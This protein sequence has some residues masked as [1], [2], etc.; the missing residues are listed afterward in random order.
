MWVNVTESGTPEAYTTS[1]LR[2]SRATWGDY[3]NSSGWIYSYGEEDWFTNSMAIARTKAGLLYTKNTG[4]TLSA[5]GFG[6]CYD[7]V[8]TNIS[9]TADPVYGVRWCGE[10][11]G[12]PEGNLAWGLDAADY[13]IT[14][15]TVCLD[16]YLKATQEYIDYCKS[17][18]ISTKVFFTTGT[19]DGGFSPV[20]K[21]YASHLKNE[22]IRNYVKADPTRIL[23]D[24]ADILCYDDDGEATTYTWEGHVFPIITPTN[25]TPTST[26][27]IS[28]AG[29]VRL[30]KAMWWMLARIAGWD[31]NTETVPVTGITVTGS[32]TI[33]TYNGTSQL[34][35]SISPTNATNQV[36]TWSI[37][38]GTGQATISTTGL[39]TAV[40]SGTVTARATAND[41]SGVYGQLVIAISNQII[42]VTGI[43]VTGATTITED[44]GTTQLAAT[45][46]PT[47]ATN[48]TITWSIINGTG[49]AT[50][51]ST[52]L[53]TAVANGTVTAR[54]TANDGSEVYGQLYITISGSGEVTKI[55]GIS[56]VYGL[57]S[58]TANRRA[59][60]ITFTEAGTIESISIYH[61]GGSG[62]V[63]LGVYSDVGGSPAMRLGV[64]PGTTISSSAGWQTITLV[65]PVSVNSGQKVWLS[66]VFENNPGLRYIRGTPARAE[67]SALW[68]G[69]MPATFGTPRFANYRYSVYCTYT[70]GTEPTT[71]TLGTSEV[72][73]LTSTT[74]NRRA[75]TITFTE[76]G[77]IES[78]S[79]YHN[80]GS[81]QVLLGVYSDV[82]G[83]PAMRLGVT[84]GTTISSSVGWQTISLASPVTVNS[85]QKLWL[86]WVFENNPGIRYIAGTPARAESSA[87]WSGGMPATFG[88]PGFANY[89][90]SVYCT[91]TSGTE[92]TTKTLGT[93]EVY[94]LTSTTAN[95]RAQTIT[96]TEAGT[97][98]SISIYHNGGNGQVLLG[99]YS[100][101]GGSPATRLG[102]TPGTTISSSAGWQTISL[103]SPVTVNSGQK[104]W[105]SWVFENNPG[106]R[107]IAG[108][109]ARAESTTL[110]Y[111]GMPST[112]GTSRFANYKYSIYCTYTTISGD[113]VKSVNEPLEVN[114]FHMDQEEVLIYPN[115]TDGDITVRWKNR[116][117]HGFDIIIYNILGKA[118]KEFQT[119]PDV[120]EIR[121]DL[122]G[123]SNGL[124][125]FE[126]K[127]EKNDLILNRSRIIKK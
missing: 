24:Y 92:P 126:M 74:A 95:R 114:S 55:I 67:S 38:N 48:K 109:L 81:G 85:G 125:L 120:N 18:N 122:E 124:Y 33:T 91:Y 30:A 105:L 56:E 106:I 50:I 14:G 13:S 5:I 46:S 8:E 44:N 22:R 116:Y 26:G 100:D 119:D 123:Y 110:W 43:T 59:Q 104:L 69:G 84:P 17:N 61:N 53:V 3:S 118:V 16:T 29:A 10:S 94:G 73:G 21:G 103:A 47:D 20:E 98:E 27:H 83:S 51:S 49:Q 15:N 32:T 121:L 39:V 34:A 2:A 36:L 66:W 62:Q 115:P 58:T 76:A 86:S 28:N 71:K 63:L 113:G 101:A 23:F 82:G 4:P 19:V 25:L 117:C 78:I 68:S 77:T 93:S 87:L 99:V 7:M 12:G 35:A 108:T 90:Y 42:P 72:Y 97:I 9:G 96:F 79:I 107:Y 52:G 80:G 45:V 112:F 31:G 89:R 64:T 54:A 75:Q 6:W 40:A 11:V 57:T 111:G 1:Y 41:G 88:T 70:S 102:V 127:D 65:N 37:T 60:T